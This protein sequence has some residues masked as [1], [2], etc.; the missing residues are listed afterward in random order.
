MIFG[1][2][3]ALKAS[4]PDLV[5]TMEGESTVG[6]ERGFR[7]SLRQILVV[8]QVSLS[9]V[10]LVGAGLLVRSL[11]KAQEVDPGFRVDNVLLVGVNVGAQGYK[12]EQ[13]K[14]FY[15]QLLER[16]RGTSGVKS[17]TIAQN[18]PFSGGI[19]RSVFLE[20]ADPTPGNRGGFVQGNAVGAKYFET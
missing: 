3:A 16:V 5:P 11:Q 13:G 10:S 20:G 15:Q 6:G 8:L 1:L 17:A 12:P 19:S 4:K 9:L 14:V 7:I 18:Q 2:A